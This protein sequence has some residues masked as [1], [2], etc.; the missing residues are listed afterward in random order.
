MSTKRLEQYELKF[1]GG[2]PVVYH[3]HH[4]NLFLDQTIDDAL[5]Q[6]GRELKRLSGRRAAA[7]FLPRMM[8]DATT[9]MERLRVAKDV[10][11]SMGHGKLYFDVAKGGGT[12]RSPSLHYGVAWKEKYGETVRTDTPKDCFASG[13]AAAA[14]ALAYGLPG[15]SLDSKETQ[16]L[17]TR[18]SQCS[19]EVTTSTAALPMG[20]AVDIDTIVPTLKSCPKGK[21]EAAIDAIV[22]GLNQFL[23]GVKPDSRGLVEA[24]G[25]YITL[26]LANYYNSISFGALREVSQR[27]PEFVDV[28]A[29]LLRESGHVCVFNTFGGIISSP[30]WEGLVGA[31]ENNPEVIATWC[32]AIAR[33]LGFG[34]WSLE[35]FRE[36]QEMVLVTPSNYEAPYFGLREKKSVGQESPEYF[37]QGASA[38]IMHLAHTVNWQKKPSFTHSAYLKL[39]E[40]GELP[41]ITEQSDCASFGTTY[42]R[43]RV[44]SR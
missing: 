35:S 20:R 17:A 41:W 1:L 43:V 32:L 10:F 8:R 15:E 16:C 36:G 38:A 26:H 5:G 4:F 21:N 18:D 33:A 37:F 12:I 2:M 29:D 13:F 22:T 9:P 7:E 34:R 42:S 25:V 24:F 40:I 19:F 31:P 44:R 28:F 3:C 23:A 30:E 27:G 6:S 11:S 39:F 14:T